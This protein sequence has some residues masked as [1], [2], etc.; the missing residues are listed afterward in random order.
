MLDL[1]IVLVSY[2]TCDLLRDCLGSV[3]ESRDD[4][5]FKVVVVDN[6]STDGSAE[7]VRQEFPQAELVISAH[8]GGYAYANNL[9]LKALGF[10]GATE[11]EA[12]GT[13][14]YVLLLNPDTV[15]PPR[16]LSD[17]RD[18][19]AARPQVG[20]AGPRLV[21]PNGELDRACRRS[22]PTPQVSFYRMTGLSRLFPRSS[23]FGAYNLTYLDEN[24][25]AE[26]DSVVGAFMMLHSS[27]IRKVG[28]LDES[29][30]MYGEDL[31]WC[32]RIHQSGWQV[33]Y[34]PNCTVLHYKRASSRHSHRAQVEFYRAMLVFYDKHYAATTPFWLHW[35]VVGGIYVRGGAV[36]L[37]ENLRRALACNNPTAWRAG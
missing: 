4:L 11:V 18:F 36:L 20:V 1:G 10:G 6:A 31:D 14:T 17:M 16:A 5:S 8:N 27:A 15:L 19:M 13:V 23:R 26:V 28:L 33:R 29:F 9:G 3:Y 22:F 25:E 34:N 32:Y 37:K 24:Q 35:L 12:L 21:L 7:M 2:N 30:F